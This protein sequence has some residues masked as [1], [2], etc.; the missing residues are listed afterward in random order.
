MYAAL[1]IGQHNNECRGDENRHR[2]E[3]RIREEFSKFLLHEESRKVVGPP[4]ERRNFEVRS[5]E[6][7]IEG[8]QFPLQDAERGLG[9]WTA[10]HRRRAKRVSKV[11]RG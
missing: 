7:D 3:V 11:T 1:S 2:A 8:V 6:D 5:Q 4:Q 9:V 10:T